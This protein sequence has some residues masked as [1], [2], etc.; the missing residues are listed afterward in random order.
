MKIDYDPQA[1]AMYIQLKEGEVD[2][3]FEVGKQI[4]VDVDKESTPLGIEI[5]FVSRR[6]A[7]EDLMTVTLNIGRAAELVGTRC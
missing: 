7:P 3:T 4:F 6:F 1:D 5:L 2:D